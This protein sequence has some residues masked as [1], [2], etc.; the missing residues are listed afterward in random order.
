MAFLPKGKESRAKP[1]AGWCF[2]THLWGEK[3]R[4]AVLPRALPP[5]GNFSVD[6]I[7]G[8]ST[9]TRFSPMPDAC[10]CPET[11]VWVFWV[12]ISWGKGLLEIS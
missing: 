8:E 5:T 11:K 7:L 6:L 10:Q 3:A 2:G 4:L 12:E 9:A 1:P